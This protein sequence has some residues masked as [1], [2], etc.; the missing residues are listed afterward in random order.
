VL[1]QCSG[2]SDIIGR[3]IDEESGPMLATAHRYMVKDVAAAIDASRAH[4]V[5]LGALAAATATYL[6]R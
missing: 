3:F 6:T 2:A 4:G 1:V 5:E